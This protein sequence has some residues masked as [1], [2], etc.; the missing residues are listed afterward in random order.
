MISEDGGAAE[1]TGKDTWRVQGCTVALPVAIRDSIVAIAVFS[2]SRGAARAAVTDNR[3]TP[4]TVAGRGFASLMFVKYRDSDLGTYDEVGLSV[5]VRGPAH[6]A[7]GAYIVELP[8]TQTFTLK[9][10]RAIWG[11]PKWLAQGTISVQR[12]GVQARLSDGAQSVLTAVLD[13][14]G[15]RIPVPITIPV[16]CWV[17]RPDGLQV[18]ELLRGIVRVRLEGLRI[19]LGGARVVLGEHRMAQTARALGM[20]D[21]PLCTVVARMT[22]ELDAFPSLGGHPG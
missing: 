1:R 14:G 4:L 10:G 3:L 2:C 19:R 6:G 7:I 21:P 12:S 9:A 13:A 16:V 11:L 8:V 20:S 22:T 15:L 5:A 18:G 17:V